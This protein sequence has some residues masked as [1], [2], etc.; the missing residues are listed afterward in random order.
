MNI[1]QFNFDL[2]RNSNFWAILES[3]D[4]LQANLF[5][6]LIHFAL[7]IFMIFSIQWLARRL[8]CQ[9]FSNSSALAI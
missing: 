7:F 8:T 9:P 3:N 5:S 2:I 4:N 6:F 1:P